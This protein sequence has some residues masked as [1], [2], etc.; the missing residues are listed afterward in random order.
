MNQESRSKKRIL[1][2]I[3]LLPLL[4]GFLVS[5]APVARALTD[6]ERCQ[7]FQ[8]QFI[9][10]INGKKINT[11]GTVPAC[12]EYSSL[13]AFVLKGINLGLAFAGIIT[14]LFIIL[15]GY[16]YVTSAGN[17]EQAEKGRKT[18]T[19]SI[20]GLVVIIMSFVIVRVI[21]TTLVENKGGSTTTPTNTS[22][23]TPGGQGGVTNPSPGGLTDA[24][25]GMLT[26]S[27]EITKE[28]NG[29]VTVSAMISGSQK[30]DLAKKACAL[31]D[32]GNLTA[33]A[34][35]V[36]FEGQSVGDSPNF[37]HPA[38]TLYMATVKLPASALKGSGNLIVYIC[39][40]GVKMM[41]IK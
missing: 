21:A 2:T 32:A 31:G 1:N 13:G 17:E 25:I 4:F 29:D 26:G 6:E 23:T 41:E 15:G 36:K 38:G 27:I 34:L 24:E 37:S 40:T 8:N 39:E 3:L 7:E 11:I 33:G 22:A 5:F 14:A 20:I 16:W 18:L 10:D 19:N 9:I 28:S 30:V 12:G 35:R